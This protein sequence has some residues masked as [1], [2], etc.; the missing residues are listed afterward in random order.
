M[1]LKA[2]PL[3]AIWGRIALDG[4]GRRR[5]AGQDASLRSLSSLSLY[6]KGEGCWVS[7]WTGTRSALASFDGFVE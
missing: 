1:P 3:A 4:D 6:T 7:F 2:L 5:L